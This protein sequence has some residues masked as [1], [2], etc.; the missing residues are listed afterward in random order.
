MNR[1][2]QERRSLVAFQL[3]VERAKVNRMQSD[4]LIVRTDHQQAIRLTSV[5]TVLWSAV[6]SNGVFRS[7][8]NRSRTWPPRELVQNFSRKLVIM[9]DS[10]SH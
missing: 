10:C 4:L 5:A 1:F 3:A 2:D 9:G 6:E 7:T 8:T